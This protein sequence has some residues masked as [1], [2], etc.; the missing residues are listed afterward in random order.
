MTRAASP[1]ASA[2]STGPQAALSEHRRRARSSR[3]PIA[4]SGWRDPPAPADRVQAPARPQVS[5][6][7][8]PRAGPDRGGRRVGLLARRVAWTDRGPASSISTCTTRRSGRSSAS[9]PPCSTRGCRATSW[10]AGWR[11]PTQPARCCARPS[12]FPAM[13]RA[14]RSTPSNWPTRSAC[15][16][17][18][19][20]GGSAI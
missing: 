2:R 11:C 9:P 4:T 12:A 14:G 8:A 17:T 15:M 1:P 13:A 5:L 3:S 18:I 16:T 19:P 20:W 10:R 6:R 7:G